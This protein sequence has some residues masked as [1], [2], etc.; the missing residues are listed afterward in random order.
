MWRRGAP[1]LIRVTLLSSR[2][3]I[4][5]HQGGRSAFPRT[6]TGGPGPHKSSKQR[7]WAGRT[8]MSVFLGDPWHTY[9]FNARP[10][11]RGW[12]MLRDAACA[13]PPV[14]HRAAIV[15]AWRRPAC[16][17]G[18]PAVRLEV[19]GKTIPAWT[20]RCHGAPVNE[21]PLPLTGGHG[22]ASPSRPGNLFWRRPPPG[23]RATSRTF[24]QVALSRCNLFLEHTYIPGSRR[25]RENE[26]GPR[27]ASSPGCGCKSAGPESV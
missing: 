22:M 15:R 6:V 13:I 25:R 27:A 26:G 8:P 16:I 17:Q 4:L 2:V 20:R 19:D 10:A 9:C 7:A 24:P 23:S 3:T 1:G 21:T 11:G 12:L 18:L 5:S 14:L